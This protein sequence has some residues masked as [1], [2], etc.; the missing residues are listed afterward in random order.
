[1]AGVYYFY[2][3]GDNGMNELSGQKGILLEQLVDIMKKAIEEGRTRDVDKII[4]EGFA[5]IETNKDG[6]IS[7]FLHEVQEASNRFN[8]GCQ[9]CE[10]KC[11]DWDK[12]TIDNMYNQ[13]SKDVKLELIGYGGKIAAHMV[14]SNK[15]SEKLVNFLYK[16]LG[17]V[18]RNVDKSEVYEYVR[19]SKDIMEKHVVN[20]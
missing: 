6:N 13:E 18:S 1:M 3:W 9:F 7:A 17:I 20:M 8:P 4:I 5:I 16:I 14:K 15:A 12:F 11:T 10:H 2:K 19:E